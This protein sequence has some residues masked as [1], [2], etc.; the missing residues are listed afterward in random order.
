MKV[1]VA[2]RGEIACRILKT[3]REMEVPSVA[4]HTPVDKGALH[5]DFADDIAAL[6]DG[7]YLDGA[8]LIAAARA[9]GAT[10]IHPG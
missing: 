1:L 9:H 10:A 7:G 6:G 8:A 3:L 4:V 2:N 5:L